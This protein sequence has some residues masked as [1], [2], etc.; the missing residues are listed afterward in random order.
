VTRLEYF[1]KR[2][3]HKKRFRFLWPCAELLC[4]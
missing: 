1:N 4:H 2:A 3:V